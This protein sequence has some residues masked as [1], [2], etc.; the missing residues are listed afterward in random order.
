MQTLNAETT[1]KKSDGPC[2]NQHNFVQSQVSGKLKFSLSAWDKCLLGT[3]SC[4]LSRSAKCLIS[5]LLFV[6]LLS[7]RLWRERLTMSS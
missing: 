1:T 7:F 6:R 3:W 4:C 2:S 5:Q